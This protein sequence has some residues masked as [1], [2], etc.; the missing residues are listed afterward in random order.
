MK[1]I[2]IIATVFFFAFVFAMQAHSVAAAT[3]NGDVNNDGK[4]DIVDYQLIQPLYG[5]TAAAG[6]FNKNGIVDSADINIVIATLYLKQIANT[7]PSP[8]KVVATPTTIPTMFPTVP[9]VTTNGIG[10]INLVYKQGGIWLT[11]EEIAQIPMDNT[12]GSS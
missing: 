11:P 3:I 7:A 4:V 9:P 1:K 6:D 10:P 12:T 2:I 8:T 5:T